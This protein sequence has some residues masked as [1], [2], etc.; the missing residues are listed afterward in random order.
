MK[1]EVEDHEAHV[2]EMKKTASEVA[3]M[4][5]STTFNQQV[6][7][8]EEDDDKKKAIAETIAED[9]QKQFEQKEKETEEKKE[10]AA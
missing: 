9:L 5:R 6:E 8:L 3:L 10:L 2:S 4:A 1:K 7:A